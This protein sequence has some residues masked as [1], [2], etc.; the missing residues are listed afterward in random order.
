MKRDL[1]L[2]VTLLACCTSATATVMPR[3]SVVPGGVAIVDVGAA[4]PPVPV[5]RFDG[6]RVLTVI[7][8]GRYKAVLGIALSTE[9]GKHMV[10]VE[11]GGKTRAIPVQ[12]MPKKYR[13]QQLKV[14]EKQVNLSPEDAARV[15]TEQKHLR[16]LYDA[17]SDNAPATFALAVPVTGPRSSSFGMRRVFNGQSRNPHSGMDIAADTGTPITAPADGT[18]VDVGSYFFNG[19]NVLIDHGG[20]FLTMYC[21][22][23][24]FAVK[25]GDV[26]RTGQLI[27]KVGATGRVTGPH[28]H[29]GVLLN[30]ASVDPALFLPAPPPPAPKPVA[31]Q[32]PAP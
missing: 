31:P 29:F 4:S 3:T 17:Q 5:V 27:G 30:G 24:A 11:A 2:I 22:L 7:D 9:P 28:L 13:E 14:P 12:V 20:G 1:L 18:V 23:S 6:H 26:V 19:N 10:S 32:K 15:E 21:H 16:A 25:A 8:G